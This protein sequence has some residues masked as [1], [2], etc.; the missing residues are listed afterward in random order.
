MKSNLLK[1]EG[2]PLFCK[3]HDKG[4]YIATRLYLVTIEG[5]RPVYNSWK[6]RYDGKEYE[7]VEWVKGMY[8]DKTLEHLKTKVEGK[9]GVKCKWI[10]GGTC[11]FMHAF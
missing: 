1:H 7:R 8:S 4:G 10:D 2:I 3:P 5:E 6:P 11:E 9:L